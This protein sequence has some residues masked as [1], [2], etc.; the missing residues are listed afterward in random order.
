MCNTCEEKSAI[1]DAW[2]ES[3]MVEIHQK[4]QL[5]R[6]IGQLEEVTRRI[7]ANLKQYSL[8]ELTQRLLSDAMANE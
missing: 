2:R 3:C 8:D 1:A 4:Q 6:R 5:L 7:A